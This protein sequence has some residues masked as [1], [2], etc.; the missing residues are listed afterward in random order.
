MSIY[1]A[2]VEVVNAA[3]SRMGV[4]PIQ[5]LDEAAKPAIVA[6]DIYEGVIRDLL[7]KHGWTFARKEEDLAYQGTAEGQYSSTFNL[8]SDLLTINVVTD[9]GGTLVDYAV[10]GN[11]VL[12][13]TATGLR[14]AYQYRALEG[15]WADDF[16]EGVVC[17][18]RAHFYRALREDE[19]AGERMERMAEMRL[20]RAMVRDKRQA[21]PKREAR[22]NGGRLVAA[23]RGSVV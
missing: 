17:M 10:V 9:T 8:P 3:L 2:P 12:A 19:V 4:R 13:N 6:N 5:G 15:D 1:S 18:L 11:K 22:I 16:A 21:P 14:L 20:M 23:W 7:T